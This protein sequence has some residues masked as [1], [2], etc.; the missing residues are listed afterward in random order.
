MAYGAVQSGLREL[1]ASDAFAG[2]EAWDWRR[3]FRRDTSGGAVLCESGI[4]RGSLPSAFMATTW[5]GVSQAV[6]LRYSSAVMIV[7]CRRHSGIPTLRPIR[8]IWHGLF[9]VLAM[10]MISGKVRRPSRGET[11]RKGGRRCCYLL[12]RG[13]KGSN[14]QPAGLESAALP[15]ELHPQMGDGFPDRRP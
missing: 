5:A 14:L 12:S 9:L 6:S 10:V 1:D 13:W 2:S 15:V 8:H 7:R 3:S 11:S 4:H